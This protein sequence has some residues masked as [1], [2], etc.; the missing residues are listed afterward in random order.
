M[1]TV[2]LEYTQQEL[3]RAY[4]QSDW[5]PSMDQTLAEYGSISEAQRKET[6]PEVLGYATDEMGDM[7]LFMGDAPGPLIYFIHGGAWKTGDRSL[8]S[9]LAKNLDH[10]N[11]PLAVPDFPKIQSIGL[12]GIVDRV[13]TALRTLLTVRPDYQQRGLILA[14]HSSGAH[15]AACL[16]TG[17]GGTDI[18]HQTTGCLLV[19]GI[20]DMEPVLIS[21][22]RSYV[23]ITSNEARKLSPIHHSDGLNGTNLTLA[24]GAHESPEFIRQA[25]AFGKTLI[26]N[27][28]AARTLHIRGHDHFSILLDSLSPDGFF[29]RALSE[30]IHDHP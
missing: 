14:G 22:R 25:E 19:S 9:F 18:A 17:A 20:Y 1:N 26:D 21:S 28:K 23:D 27:G 8:Y 29:W 12:P 3:D 7:D 11:C 24:Y 6:P 15:L 2:Y 5:A 4:Q 16:A 13:A 30:L 10:I